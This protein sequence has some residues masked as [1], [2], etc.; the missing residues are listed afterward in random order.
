[1]RITV[2]SDPHGVPDFAVLPVALRR[3]LA[4]PEGSRDERSEA[5]AE[6]PFRLA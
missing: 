1:L 5:G 6:G 3:E 4:Q 2:I